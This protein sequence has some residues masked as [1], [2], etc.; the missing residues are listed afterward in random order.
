ML[1]ILKAISEIEVYSACKEDAECFLHRSQGDAIIRKPPPFAFSVHDLQSS[2]QFPSIHRSIC[3]LS[4][5][6]LSLLSVGQ[7]SSIA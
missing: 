1:E 7:L 4:W 6:P 2:V 5:P 3:L